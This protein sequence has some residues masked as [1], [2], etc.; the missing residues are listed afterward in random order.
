MAPRSTS[1]ARSSRARARRAGSGSW[2]NRAGPSTGPSTASRGDHRHLRAEAD[3]AGDRTAGRAAAD[4][5]GEHHRRALHDR[6]RRGASPTSTGAPRSCSSVTSTTSSVVSCGRS[7]R[8]PPG[9]RSTVAFRRAL[10]EDRTVVL[11]EYHYPPLERYFS[12][13]VYPSPQGLAVYFRDVTDQRNDRLELE[14]QSAR[15]AEQA[16][17]L[18]EAQDAILV[19][20]LDGCI[21]FWNRSAERI[22]GWSAEEASASRSRSCCSSTP[23]PSSGR[24]G[25]AA[26][27][28]QL[29]GRGHQDHPRRPFADHR[30]PLDA[31]PRR[32][33]HPLLRAGDRFRRHRAQ[34]ARAAVPAVAAHGEPRQ[35]RRRDRPRPQQRPRADLRL[36]R[37]AARP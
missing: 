6:H 31:G 7:S 2:A 22:Y 4:H 19:R 5:D 15:L 10:T 29:G 18:D 37:A 16:A 8:R 32:R 3:A 14:Q 25:R 34:A 9:P 26:G 36:P 30:D 27:A 11:D 23:R 1:S 33:R 13:N 35:A 21:S 28:G 17:L 12:V 20:D 24:H